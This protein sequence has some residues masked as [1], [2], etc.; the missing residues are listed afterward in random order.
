[1][2]P[3]SQMMPCKAPDWHAPGVPLVVVQSVV[4]L[5]RLPPLTALQDIGGSHVLGPSARRAAF[6]RG[7]N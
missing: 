3:Q 7:V 5:R 4:L 1:M 2:H 6:D